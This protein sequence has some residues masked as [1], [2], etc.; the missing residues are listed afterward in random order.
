MTNRRIIRGGN[1]PAGAPA[2][3]AVGDRI[4]TSGLV[5][6]RPG[7]LESEAHRV[8]QQ[9]IAILRDA[10]V[11]TADVVRTR[12]WHV[13]TD[14]EPMLRDVHGVVFDHPGPA[15]SAVQASCL[16]GNSAVLLELEAI[17]GAGGRIRR[18][19]SDEESATSLATEADG[20]VWLGGVTA[21]NADGTVDH[22]ADV[23]EQVRAVVRRAAVSVVALG[24]ATSDVVA[25]RHFMRHDTQGAARPTEWTEFMSQAIPTSAG[26]AVEGVGPGEA[27]FMLELEAVKGALAGRRNL[28]T[29]RT[30]EVENNYCRSVRVNGGDVVYVAGTTS[31]VPGEIVRHPG[32]VAGQVRDTLETIRWAVEEQGLEWTDL[33]RTRTYVVGGP[34][35]LIEAA[36]ALGEVLGDQAAVAA[37]V[38]VPALG[39]PE[40]VVEIEATAV[41][42]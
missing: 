34:E 39:R 4:F 9:A 33:A 16:P 14:A 38:G 2:L 31:L 30:Y 23:T 37:L 28:R 20:E 32:E 25:T 13:D 35:K 40:V 21:A 27:A 12:V 3:V 29:G 1:L 19:E 42:G 5:S 41:S 7:G 17:R 26:I 36:G 18:Y 24:A 11:S 22:P 10:G 15:F 8:F 6:D